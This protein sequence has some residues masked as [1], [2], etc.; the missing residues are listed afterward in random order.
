MMT[1]LGLSGVLL[2]LAIFTIPVSD[3]GLG[4][5]GTPI[6]C[7]P[8]CLMPSDVEFPRSFRWLHVRIVKALKLDRHPKKL[9][10]PFRYGTIEDHPTTGRRLVDPCHSTK[11]GLLPVQRP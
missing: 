11:V 5:L 1:I 2:L 10:N 3:D 4:M 6:P 7:I 9:R 8:P